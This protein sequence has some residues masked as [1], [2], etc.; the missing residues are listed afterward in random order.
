MAN[1]RSLSTMQAVTE[2]SEVVP[3]IVSQGQTLFSQK[4]CPAAY[5]VMQ[6][7]QIRKGSVT[8]VT[9]INKTS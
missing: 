3:E 8:I 6:F 5:F 1:I 9:S 4:T 2:R 7:I